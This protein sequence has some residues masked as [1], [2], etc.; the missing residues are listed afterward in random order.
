M[1]IGRV[2]VYFKKNLQ[3]LEL[4]IMK[5]LYAS[6]LGIDWFRPLRIE[7]KGINRIVTTPGT[8]TTYVRNSPPSLIQVW[9]S[10]MDPQSLYRSAPSTSRTD[11]Y[12]SP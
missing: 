7:V 10:T 3:E 12:P 6:L 2:S 1:G 8:I 9:T 11:R 5:S 4:V